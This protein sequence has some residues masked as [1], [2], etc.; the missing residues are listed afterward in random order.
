[1][2]ITALKVGGR[3]FTVQSWKFK[4]AE[5]EEARGMVNTRTGVIRIA[6]EYATDKTAETI[7]HEALHAIFSD[8]GLDWSHDDEEKMVTRLSPR[9]TAFIADN[10]AAIRELLRMLAPK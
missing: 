9:L 4:D 2:K 8:I 1:M 6:E 7:I 10:P 3:T 5:D